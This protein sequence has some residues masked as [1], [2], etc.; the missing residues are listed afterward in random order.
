VRSLIA[1]RWLAVLVATSAAGAASPARSSEGPRSRWSLGPG[2]E[3]YVRGLIAPFD[4]GTPLPGG[5]VVAD[6]RVEPDG[7]GYRFASGARSFVLVLRRADE[8]GA[9]QSRNFR[10]ELDDSAGSLTPEERAAQLASLARLVQANDRGPDPWLRVGTPV[11]AP[12]NPALPFV[13]EGDEAAAPVAE[14]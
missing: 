11:A 6:I 5:F 13:D 7:V 2:H 3:D 9:P 1:G 14:D 10:I 4:G 12:A 8:S